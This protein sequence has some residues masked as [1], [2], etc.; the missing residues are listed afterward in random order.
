MIYCFTSKILL[1]V[2][3]LLL[4]QAIQTSQAHVKLQKVE[5]T[6]VRL[7]MLHVLNL[8]NHEKFLHYSSDLSYHRNQM[9]VIKN[10]VAE[11]ISQDPSSWSA[12]QD[13]INTMEEQLQ[14]RKFLWFS[15]PP[16]Q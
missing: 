6:R 12:T 10:F 16:T 7:R 8:L 4:P 15:F 13:V 5:A 14:N 2:C 9:L 11:N 3:I 1:I